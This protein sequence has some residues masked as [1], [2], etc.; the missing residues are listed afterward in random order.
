[1]LT[2]EQY[3]YG[4]AD[5]ASDKVRSL[6]LLRQSTRS[7]IIQCLADREIQKEKYEKSGDLTAEQNSGSEQSGAYGYNSGVIHNPHVWSK[8]CEHYL[9]QS[10]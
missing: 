2:R 8:V 1:M 7:L 3:E 4:A 10:L 9:S 6:F 5:N